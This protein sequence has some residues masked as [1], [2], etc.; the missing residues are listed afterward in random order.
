MSNSISLLILAAGL[1]SRFSGDKQIFAISSLN[2]PILAFSLQDAV[3]N[4]IAHAVI[5]TRSD[6]ADFFEKNIFPLFPSIRFDLV[7]Q[8]RSPSPLPPHRIK[9]WGTGHAALCAKNYIHGHFIVANADDFYGP[10]A[11][12]EAALFLRNGGANP[13]CCIGYPLLHTL[14]PNGPVSRGIIQI[15]GQN[16]ITSIIEM[17]KIQRCPGG[18]ITARVAPENY[19]IQNFPIGPENFT[20]IDGK[21]FSQTN[22]SHSPLAEKER[23]LNHSTPILLQPQQPVSLNLFGLHASIFPILEQE[24]QNFFKKNRDSPTAEFGLPTTLTAPHILNKIIAIKMLPTKDHWL[25]I[26]YRKDLPHVEDQ[27]NQL[28]ANGIYA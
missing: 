9:P 10:S 22:F 7:F 8:D 21:N 18:T 5:L 19:A 27:L 14:S 24:F 15:D 4:E 28:I 6:L 1:G 2:L 17:A 25:G 11:I 20:S 13:C 26:T 16:F 23:D 12:G 3:K